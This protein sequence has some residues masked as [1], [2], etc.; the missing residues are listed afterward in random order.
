[1]QG[2]AASPA[3][4]V[5]CH[6][7]AHSAEQY[8]WVLGTVLVGTRKYREYTISVEYWFAGNVKYKVLLS[9]NLSFIK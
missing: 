5:S 9:S 8:W 7:R 3:P 2:I 4:P 6:L 1:M